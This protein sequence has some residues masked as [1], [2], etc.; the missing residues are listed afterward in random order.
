VSSK[1]GNVTWLKTALE[2]EENKVAS[3]GG[4]REKR[5]LGQKVPASCRGTPGTIKPPKVSVGGRF[6]C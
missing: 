1:E 3:G 4:G 5:L 2:V 6:N